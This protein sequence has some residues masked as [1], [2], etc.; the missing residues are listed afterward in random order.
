MLGAV[1]GRS[2]PETTEAVPGQAGGICRVALGAIAPAVALAVVWHT[3]AFVLRHH[4]A[5][6]I[7]DGWAPW[8]SLRQVIEGRITPV[9]ALVARHNEH[10]ILVTRLLF[11]VDLLDGGRDRISTAASLAF[12]ALHVGIWLVLL[13]RTDAAPALRWLVGGTVVAM[14]F[15]LRQGENFVSGFQAQFTGV[16]ALNV[17]VALLLLPGTAG[18]AEVGR[19]ARRRL[20]IGTAGL[21]ALPFTMVN[22]LLAGPACAATG[23][24]M[25][26]RAGR[27]SALLALSVSILSVILD[28]ALP[29]DGTRAMTFAITPT[30]ALH[31]LAYIGGIVTSGRVSWA[32]AAGT[33]GIMSSLSMA[34]TVLR[35]GVG[36]RTEAVAVEA[37]LFALM[38]AGATAV[39]RVGAGFGVEQALSGRYATGSAAFWA[40][41]LVFWCARLSGRHA[42]PRRERG[43]AV[44][45]LGSVLLLLF[46]VR[47]QHSYDRV[48]AGQ[49][50]AA[51]RVMAAFKADAVPA[52]SDL[53]HI[54]VDL[55]TAAADMALLR[56][57]RAID[58]IDAPPLPRGGGFG[59]RRGPG[60]GSSSSASVPPAALPSPRPLP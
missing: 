9:Q 48:L 41:T 31:A 27:V 60:D 25:R 36:S 53:L 26:S 57:V 20:A 49:D 34:L 30:A 39:G 47:D 46:V 44:L 14:L 17:A 19:P 40:A 52:A 12:Q 50:A 37:V 35:R 43:T 8:S 6:P 59:G 32:L 1:R 10:R 29:S 45:A 55:P 56:G 24:L 7:A 16:F 13:R 15:T 2:A 33:A 11:L 3:L 38:S 28:R 22:G 23:L 42:G 51:D 18:D 54:D 4:P 58:G 21:L 5:L